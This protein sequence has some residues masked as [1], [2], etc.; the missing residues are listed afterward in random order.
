MQ[1]LAFG[2]ALRIDALLF[3]KRIP[4]ARQLESDN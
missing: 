2:D 3:L 4:V 1:I